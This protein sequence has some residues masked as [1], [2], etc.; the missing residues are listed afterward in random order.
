MFEVRTALFVFFPRW[1]ELGTDNRLRRNKT[2]V[3]RQSDHQRG[4]ILNDENEKSRRRRGTR[5]ANEIG[6]Y[7]CHIFN[8]CGFWRRHDEGGRILGKETPGRAEVIARSGGKTGIPPGGEEIT[9]DSDG[10]RQQ[11]QRQGGAA[12]VHGR[13]YEIQV[14]GCQVRGPPA[15]LPDVAGTQ[16]RRG[17]LHRHHFAR[18]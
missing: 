5:T 16:G 12:C 4:V 13:L 17:Q 8:T 2:S 18:R 11:Q 9:D 14:G 6:F 15:Q 3:R 1:S 7:A 10:T